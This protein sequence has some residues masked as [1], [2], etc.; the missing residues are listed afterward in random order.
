[1]AIDPGEAAQKHRDLMAKRSR[2]R[3]ADVAEIGAIPP[4]ANPERRESCRLDLF[5]F[6]TT[7]FP[8][9]TGLSP[10]SD[11]HRKVI[12]RMQSCILDGG[13][14]VNAVYRGFAKTT[15]SENAAIWAILYGHRRFVVV[16]GADATAADQIVE[17]VKG[18]LEGNDLL[19]E[20]FPEACHAIRALE[21]K[22]QRCRSQLHQGEL[23]K[24]DWTAGMIVLARIPG[25]PCASGIF[26]ARGIGAGFRGLKVKTPDGQNQRPDLII[27]D[28]PQTDE[29]AATQAQ[30]TKTL[31]IFRKAIV[32]LGGHRTR[33]AIVV[34]ATVI[35]PDD[36]IATLLE[37]KA[38]Q[39]ERI[40]MVKKWPDAHSTLWLDDYA[41]L[42]RTYDK[43]CLDDQTRAHAEA[44]AFYAKHRE[45]MDAGGE[46]SWVHCYDHANEL[47]A[48]QHAYNAYIDDGEE[49]F[50]SEYQNAPTIPKEKQSSLVAADI[51][52]RINLLARGHAGPGMSVLT[53]FIDV[54]QE[55]LFWTVCGWSEGFSGAVVDYGV[56]PDQ[57][58]EFFL[59]R[60]LRHKLSTQ[61][62]GG[63][64]EAS[65]T[66][67]LKMLVDV[68]AV[69]SFGGSRLDRIM[70]DTGYMKPVID[71][72]IR[73]SPYA[74]I[75]TASR[76]WGVTA[77]SQ[78]LEEWV[79][80]P[81]QIRGSNWMMSA[82]PDR[83]L[84]YDTNRWKSFVEKRLL[85]PIGGKGALMLFGDEPQ[86][87]QL[88]ADHLTSEYPTKTAGRGREIDVWKVHVGRDNHWWDCLVGCAVGASF[89]G[90]T[91]AELRSAEQPKR[92]KISLN[93]RVG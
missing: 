86:K 52:K 21:G 22:P 55:A 8:S 4:V 11:D 43:D 56:F 34:N 6:L 50:L 51:T 38:W 14:F 33:L 44:T 23:T 39:G 45:E 17:S 48:I 67:G 89:Q 10:F 28:D 29:S 47:S 75:L 74:G 3:H 59:L 60:N 70:I 57:K 7:Y 93:S 26:T 42:R 36:A 30:V 1:M 41:T 84:F 88:F 16:F 91:L 9:T 85:T 62:P 72:F 79:K 12:A 58:R 24:I 13:R 63:G 81:G 18:E 20:D 15:I 40:A 25:A 80:K 65:I 61:F 87:H 46:I 82:P 83:V 53:A 27:A 71:Q 73:E 49:A 66:A 2:D 92:R 32:K 77:A 90:V 78:D 5:K 19:Y 76:G 54:Q 37:D 68:L 31:N 64:T 35:Q 69:Q